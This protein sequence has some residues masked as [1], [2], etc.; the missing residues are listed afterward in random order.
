MIRLCL[1]AALSDESVSL[2]GPPGIVKSPIVRRLKFAFLN[3]RSFVYLMTLFSTPKEV[4][5]SLSIH[6]LLD[7]GRYQGLTAGYL[8]QA[9]IMFLDEIWR[10]AR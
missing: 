9:E 10:P 2:L 3:I 8:P 5:G 6:T 4:F 1:L 7:E